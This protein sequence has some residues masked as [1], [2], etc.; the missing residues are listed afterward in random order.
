VRRITEGGDT[1][2]FALNTV[3][4]ILDLSGISVG[5]NIRSAHDQDV[6]G[7]IIDITGEDAGLLIGRRGQTLQA[8]QFMV[9]M[10]ARN[11][12]GES[13]PDGARI[14]VDV[15]RYRQRREGSLKDMALRVASRVAQTGRPIAL[16]PM[17]A[18]DRRVI[19]MSLANNSGVSTESVGTGDDR[20]VQILPASG[21]T[22]D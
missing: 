19:H 5:I 15:E 16:E 1:A 7:P 21:T 2:S 3:K 14:M 17:P 13:G 12:P 22:Q 8:L 9:N 4:E 10:I 18:A 11:R 20:R 6:G